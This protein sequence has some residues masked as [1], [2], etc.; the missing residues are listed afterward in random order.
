MLSATSLPTT[1]D[2]SVSFPVAAIVR[3][4]PGCGKIAMSGSWLPCTR[5]LIRELKS[6][7]G[8]N[9]IVTPL[10]FAQ[11]LTTA[12]KSS[13]WFPVKPYMISMLLLVLDEP[14]P[15]PPELRQPAVR[16]AAAP[17][18]AAALT[19]DLMRMCPPSDRGSDPGFERDFRTRDGG[20]PRG[21]SPP[22]RCGHGGGWLGAVSAPRT[23]A[24]RTAWRRRGRRRRR[25]AGRSSRPSSGAS[26]HRRGW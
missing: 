17:S 23:R 9:L 7:V 16:A 3:M 13:D 18:T 15:P 12:L 10:L 14:P 24:V 8:E 1:P 21:R 19:V 25:P 11:S 2:R 5:V 22:R 6:G 26:G 4:I 20:R